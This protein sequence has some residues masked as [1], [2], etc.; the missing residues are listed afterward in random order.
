MLQNVSSEDL[1]AGGIFSKE[2]RLFSPPK[3]HRHLAFKD[4][5]STQA[6]ASAA[7]R[8]LYLLD[9]GTKNMGP[10]QT[11]GSGP[12]AQGK[13][14]GECVLVFVFAEGRSGENGQMSIKASDGVWIT[15]TSLSNA[16]LADTKASL[17]VLVVR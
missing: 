15:M 10:D 16:L 13:S 5:A 2:L 17:C 11:H 14:S 9:D 6:D 12:R 3:L 1:R 7:V 4:D 8:Q